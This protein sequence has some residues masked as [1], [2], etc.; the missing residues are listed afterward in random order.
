MNYDPEEIVE[1][2]L[3]SFINGDREREIM[4]EL[5]EAYDVGT[6]DSKHAVAMVLEGFKRAGKIHAGEELPKSKFESD[7]FFRIAVKL[8]LEHFRNNE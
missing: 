6:D 3:K 2:V 5:Y 1:F 4:E 7:E 8:G